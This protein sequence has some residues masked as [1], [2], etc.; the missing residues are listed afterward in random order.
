MAKMRVK[1]S[2]SARIVQDVE[3][4]KARCEAGSGAGL[5]AEAVVIVRVRA[6]TGAGAGAGACVGVWKSDA[7][8]R[9][10]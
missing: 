7:S 8:H 3:G 2:E 9:P 5:L 6:G 4:V 1:C 10:F